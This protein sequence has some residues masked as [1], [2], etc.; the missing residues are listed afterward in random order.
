MRYIKTFE[1]VQQETPPLNKD[2][3]YSHK[4]E[5]GE[6]IYSEKCP[7]CTCSCND[8]SC[9]DCECQDCQKVKN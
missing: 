7:D 5:T 1:Q 9:S 6:D 3:E 2:L 4:Q 8:C